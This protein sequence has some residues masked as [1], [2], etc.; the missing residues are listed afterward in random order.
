[1]TIHSSWLYNTGERRNMD[2]QFKKGVLELIVLSLV[3]EQDIYGYELVQ[4]VSKIIDV[5]EG[6]IYPLLKRLTNE[7]YFETYYQESS[8]GPARK[9]YTI[10]DK[11]IVRHNEL[12]NSWKLFN[13]KVN[14]FLESGEKN[15][16][17]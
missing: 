7:F 17:K 3:K 6:T 1:M 5:N 13:K 12:Y 14:D 10:T 11:G 9:Y 16:K 4:Q 8:G 2:T 15:E